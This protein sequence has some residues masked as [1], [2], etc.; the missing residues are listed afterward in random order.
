MKIKY[1]AHSSFLM[2]TVKG[3]RILTDPYESGSYGGAMGY[4]KIDEPTDVITISHNHSDH[5]YI[6]REHDK[7]R[8]FRETGSFVFKGIAI[9][10]VGLFHDSSHGSER[11]SNI[12]Y[13]YSIDGVN[14]CHLGDLG[15]IPN[16]SEISE[17]G[18]VDVLMMPVGGTFTVNAEEAG[19]VMSLLGP[20]ICL[21]MHYKTKSVGFNLGPLEDF[22]S[23]RSNVKKLNDSEAEI[24]KA[25]L[26][27]N[28]EIWVLKPLKL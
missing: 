11:G 10:G 19:K 25:A 24:A 15:H 18:P 27:Q 26:P 8:I 16:S 23:G 9:R 12:A 2:T 20:K 5:N 14:F 13:V 21:P 4:R 28:A 3:T 17:I 7:A 6:S 22:T 1:F